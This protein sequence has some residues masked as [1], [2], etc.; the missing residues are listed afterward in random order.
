M[1]KEWKLHRAKELAAEA[2][3]K[4]AAD[5]EAE[6]AAAA[7][8][9]AAG[10]RGGKKS[11]GGAA[12]KA[13]AKEKKKPVP[14]TKEDFHVFAPA[15]L[16]EDAIER[17]EI[18]QRAQESEETVAELIQRAVNEVQVP[19]TVPITKLS[20]IEE[21][22][23]RSNRARAMAAAYAEAKKRSGRCQK[24]SSSTW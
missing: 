20:S 16:P 4:L 14:V 13:K 5:A 19:K 10:G 7:A 23:G 22:S 24:E 8:A 11:K 17:A 15:F 3:K 18:L 12:G 1:V 2:K 21:K 9:A 6:A